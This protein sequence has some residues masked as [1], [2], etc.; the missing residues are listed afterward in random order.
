MKSFLSRFRSLVSITAV[1]DP[2]TDIVFRSADDLALWYPRWIRHG[3]ETLQ[4]QD[5]LRCVGK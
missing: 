4:C 1:H 3:L 5:V 2:M